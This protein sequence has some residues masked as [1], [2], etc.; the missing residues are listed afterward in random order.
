MKP[1]N[2]EHIMLDKVFSEIAEKGWKNFSLLRFSKTQK[3]P[4]QDLKFFFGVKMR[5][6]TNLLK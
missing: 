3:I 6:W 2:Q 5:F 1:L 4:A